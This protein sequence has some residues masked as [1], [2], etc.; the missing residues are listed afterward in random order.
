MK[1]VMLQVL[2]NNEATHT[3]THTTFLPQLL[4][5]ATYMYSVDLLIILI[6]NRSNKARTAATHLIAMLSTTIQKT[7]TSGKKIERSLS[8]AYLM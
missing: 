2:K 4:P 3:H 7:N 1:C 6:Q 8:V 5:T